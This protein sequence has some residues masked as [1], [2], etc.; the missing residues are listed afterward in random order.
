MEVALKDDIP[1]NHPL[2]ADIAEP[3]FLSNVA[4]LS[5]IDLIQGQTLINPAHYERHEQ[6]L[7]TID[8]ST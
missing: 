7:C 4:E 2:K 8:G 5:S 6:V 1:F 3:G